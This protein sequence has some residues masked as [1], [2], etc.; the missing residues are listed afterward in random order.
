MPTTVIGSE[1]YVKTVVAILSSL[2][3]A[4][5]DTTKWK[6]SLGPVPA[7]FF[8]AISN[9]IRVC[10]ADAPLTI[11]SFAENNNYMLLLGCTGR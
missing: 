2:L 9:L 4:M 1:A 8:V 5:S 3:M 7:F 10:T 6:Y 11:V